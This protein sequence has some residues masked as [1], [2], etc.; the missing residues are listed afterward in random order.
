M[1]KNNR[2]RHAEKIATWDLIHKY[3]PDYK[4]I[5][6]GDATMSPYEILQPS[7]SVEENNPEWRR[8]VAE[9]DDR[10]VPALV[11]LNPEPEGLWQYRQSIT[12][13]NQIMKNRMYPVTLASGLEQAMKV[14]SK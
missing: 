4:V 14:L 3:T 6:V 9:P 7:G 13:I 11:W 12:V 5:F 1:W 8:G 10:A 2:R